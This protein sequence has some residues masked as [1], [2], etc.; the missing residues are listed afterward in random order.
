IDLVTAQQDDR[1]MWAK[2]S[3]ASHH[4]KGGVLSHP[5]VDHDTSNE[6]HDEQ[7]CH[8]LCRAVSGHHLIAMGLERGGYR[9]A[10][11]RSVGYVENCVESHRISSLLFPTGRSR[12]QLP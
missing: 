5:V 2:S 7:K 12:G 8:R 9:I 10:A 3:Q 11:G 6:T 1:N 4:I